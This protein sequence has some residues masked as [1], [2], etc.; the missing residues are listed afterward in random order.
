MD[1]GDFGCFKATRTA[2]SEEFHPECC[3]NTE[4]IALE[5]EPGMTVTIH[6]PK[7]RYELGRFTFAQWSFEKSDPRK[8]FAV[9]VL[10]LYVNLT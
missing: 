9:E 6:S 5:R 1:T 7:K 8:V 10:Y 4:V 3:G 2:N